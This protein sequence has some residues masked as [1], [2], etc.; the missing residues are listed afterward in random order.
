MMSKVHLVLFYTQ[1][2]PFD[3]GLN[4]EKEAKQVYNQAKGI[5]DHVYLFTPEKC[6]QVFNDHEIIFQDQREWVQKQAIEMKLPF[7]WSAN[8]AALNFLLW[9]PA[10]IDHLL[11]H[12][13]SISQDDII[14]YHDVNTTRYPEYLNG[15]KNWKLYVQKEL[16]NKST[17]LFTDY[18]MKLTTDIKREL[19]ERSNLWNYE[20]SQKPHIW[21]GAMAFRRDANA[22]KFVGE[23]LKLC[24][25]IDNLSPVTRYQRTKNFI[26][27]SQEQACLSV[28]YHSAYQSDRTVKLKY[29]L[30]SRSIPPTFATKLRFPVR[31]IARIIREH[32]A[33]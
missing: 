19:L 26:K 17:L 24:L 13:N 25:D 1:G 33:W 14:F 12:S 15:I 6:R 8:W 21:A 31:M 28:L 4:L 3:K 2:E 18:K 23:W 22:Q 5:F 9:K 29:L 10:L 7:E 32:F 11:N 20:Y 30:E 27:H 16:K